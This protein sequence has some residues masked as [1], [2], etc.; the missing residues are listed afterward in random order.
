[1]IIC[2]QP[3]EGL[4]SML[5][6][7]NDTELTEKIKS[8]AREERELTRT[9]IEHIAEIDRRKT[10]LAMAYSSLYEYLIKEIGYSEGA[11]QRRIDAAR[12]LER[13]PEVAAK[14]ESG[15]I[16]LSQISKLQ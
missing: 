8:L 2:F 3:R 13:V 15:A 4:M 10:F 16:N 7:L 11:A 6:K 1:M 12:L 9:I 5:Q 14:I